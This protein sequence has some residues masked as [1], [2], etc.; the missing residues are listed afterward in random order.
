MMADR[1]N[2]DDEDENLEDKP[3]DR[4]NVDETRLPAVR[5]GAAERLERELRRLDGPMS[6][7]NALIPKSAGDIG[8]V[9]IE[10]NPRA[11]DLGYPEGYECGVTEEAG[12]VILFDGPNWSLAGE[13]YINADEDDFIEDLSE[14]N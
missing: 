2:D 6:V 12:R 9:D 13:T 8:D 10:A 1:P 7:S 4:A 5:S 11:S 14:W 3:L